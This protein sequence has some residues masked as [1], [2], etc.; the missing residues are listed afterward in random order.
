MRVLG[1]K[2][3][4]KPLEL[5][6]LL[7]KSTHFASTMVRQIYNIPMLTKIEKQSKRRK[8]KEELGEIV[9]LGLLY[10]VCSCYARG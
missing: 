1:S 3:N 2:N 9:H 8:R 10:W 4:H 7:K 5:K 6:S